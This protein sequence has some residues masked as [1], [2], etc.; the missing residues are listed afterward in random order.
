MK[1]RVIVIF[2]IV[3][4]LLV[5]PL[6]A[7]AAFWHKWFKKK[8]NEPVV[9]I[10]QDPAKVQDYSR[11]IY[12]ASYESHGMMNVYKYNDDYYFE[13]PVELMGR[14]M[15]VVNK[16]TY[17]PAELNR[18]GVNR[19]S[20]YQS[21]MVRFELDD[22]FSTVGMKRQ[23]S[24]P[25]VSADDAIALSVAD[26]YVAPLIEKFSV[27]GHSKDSTAVVI[28][29][30]DLFDGSNTVINNLFSNMNM[31]S[32]VN[33]D[34]SRIKE[35][36]AYKDNVVAYSELT[37]RTADG[38]DE[39]YVTAGVSCSIVLLPAV[40]MA[41]RDDSPRVGYFTTSRLHYSDEQQR[42][43][44]RKYITRW[45]LEPSD[46]AAYMCG[47]V[48]RPVKPIKFYIDNSVPERWRPY[49]AQGITDWN[50]AFERAGFKDAIVVEQY[51]DSIA[52][53]DI[54]YST[55]NYAASVKVNAM[56]PSTLDPRT[57]EILEADIMWWHNVLSAL[58]QWIMVQT[59]AIN[60]AARSV[61]LP[62]SLIGDA[63]RYVVCHE[64]GHSL[65]LRHNMIASSAIPTDSLRSPSFTSAFN[66]TSASVMDYAR[67]NYV[68][69]PGDGVTHVSPHIGPYDY[70]A[71]EY[72]YRWY[73]DRV[74]EVDG[75]DELLQTHRGKLYK[76]S[77]AQ[78]ARDAVDPRAQSEDLGDDACRSS[79][80]GIANL[81][82]V[83]ENLIAWTTTGERNQTYEEASR[84]Y[85]AVVNQWNYYMYHVLANV[86]GIYLENT[87][88]GDGVKTFT[89]VEKEKQR[90]AVKFLIENA[91]SEQK[92]LFG[93]EVQDYTFLN[94]NTQN[95]LVEYAPSQVFKNAQAYLF[96]DL[97]YN[98]RLLRMLENEN[99][100]G[101]EAY[102]AVELLD[103]L[104][105]SI[106]AVTMRGGK[107]NVCERNT[108]K[109]FVDAL[110]TA[111]SASEG[112]KLNRS[113]WTEPQILNPDECVVC[114]YHAAESERAGA[115]RELSFYGSL[116]ARTSDAISVKRGE[117][118]RIKDLLTSR[119]ATSDV[120]TRYH[121]KDLILR[122]NN[123]LEIK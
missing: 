54:N 56:G 44:S 31:G 77:E 84:L 15:L 69:Q 4:G 117:L 26:N 87:T 118:L 113:L 96:F 86:G 95:G 20:D 70:F 88:V 52:V 72:G 10:E 67:F 13:I 50:A 3:L 90:R 55:V 11:I 75:L 80:L 106:F 73:P 108:Q 16:L 29:V 123:A 9:V 32:S 63:I 43:D 46:T 47:E 62:D 116:V 36:V 101:K 107:P 33:R 109:L 30:T 111:A 65:G 68:A 64:V 38:N 41:G 14:D 93:S 19:G 53:D 18:I 49:L 5:S 81:K 83:M 120:A 61:V 121:Y 66:A 110:I 105:R 25:D 39:M 71:I 51:P 59:G 115:R 99:R 37:T 103:D 7:D 28:K 98:D 60:P 34:L 42:V 112:I 57:G 79:E 27:I 97:L 102:T 24:M 119:S 100:N 89:H 21:M 92:W 12:N 23:Y 82:I 45:R 78:P 2:A 6:S 91:F 94:R 35:I 114:P 1:Q 40:P 58:Q 85:Y 76:Y 48:V 104:H 74:S 17:V 122:I 8:K 22:D